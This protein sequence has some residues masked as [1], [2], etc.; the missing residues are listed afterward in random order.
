MWDAAAIAL[1]IIASAI[2]LLPMLAGGLGSFCIGAPESNDPQIFIWGLAWYPYAISH[3][4]DPL[5]TNL[6][7]APGGYNLAWSTT[8]PAPALLM[9]AITARFGPLVSFNLLS[10]LAPILSAYTA[11]ALGR[12]ISKAALPAIVGGFVY[13]FSTYQRIEADHLNLAL[14]FIPPLLVSLFLLRLENRVGRLRYGFQLFACLTIQFLI[15]PE[16]FATAILFGTVAVA[17]SWRIGDSDL[18]L[19]LRAPLRESLVAFAI[20]VV[21]LS[22]YI[23]RF[24][25]SPFGLSP[26]YNPA[27]CS[28]DLLGLIFPTGASVLGGLKFMGVLSR[29]IRFGCEPAA[30]MGVLPVIA[31]WLALGRRANSSKEFQLERYLVLLLTVIILLALGPVIHVA[32]AAIAP[33]IW[34]PALFFPIINNTLPARFILYGFLVL[35]IVS[36]LWL[37]D[38]RRPATLRWLVAATAMVSVLPTAIPAAQATV[39]FFSEGT[40]HAYLPPNET[41]MI[42]PFA[43]NGEA[44]QWQAQSAFHFRVAGGYFS[45]IP[46]E[47]MA[48]PIVPALLDEAPYIPGYADQFKAFLAA[49]DAHAIMVPETAYPRYAKLCATLGGRPLHVRGVV[50]L[51]LNS[52]DLLPFASMSAAAMDTRYNLDRFTILIRATRDFLAGGNFARDVTP[53]AVER[54]GLL[55]AT[56]A[57]DPLRPQIADYPFINTVRKSGAFRILAGYLISHGMIRERLAIELGSHAPGAAV[58]TGGIWLGAWSGDSIAIGV[59]AGPQAAAAVIKRFG[60]HADAIYYPYPLS[61]TTHPPS[62]NQSAEPQMLLMTFKVEALPALDVS[63]PP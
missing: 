60:S 7:F 23:C 57:G 56:V 21:A 41:V 27:H 22:P 47:Y 39:P 17:A 40:Y 52:A 33:G 8:I 15:S 13:G 59:L 5:F 30:Y 32:G 1:Y 6:V 46:H 42:L 2:F 61:Y 53:F 4:L 49:H 10:L 34:L 58:S 9:W 11:F 19:R 50:F 55:D 38:R 43:S 12:H 31:I 14:T 16:I 63:R 26:I 48:W 18:R 44:M 28:S 54:L 36:A 37:S 3:R 24:I 62:A 35:S 25:P 20:A 45:V 51:H 29:R